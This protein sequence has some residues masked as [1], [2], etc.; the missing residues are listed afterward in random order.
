MV[1]IGFHCNGTT[2]IELAP[3]FIDLVF[4]SHH[5]HHETHF[6]PFPLITLYNTFESMFFDPR[7]IC[8]NSAEYT[9]TRPY[10]V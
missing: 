1:C 6:P 3:D 10:R 8:D 5:T 4:L 2:S 7:D 9:E